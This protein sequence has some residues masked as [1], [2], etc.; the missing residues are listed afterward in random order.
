MIASIAT[1]V[2]PVWRSPMISSRWPRPIGTIESI[3]FRP[4]CTG[5]STD[6]RA[7]T[8]G[9]TFSMTS[10]ILA[11]IGPLPSIGWPSAL[12]TRPISS[13]PTG[14]S[15]MRLVHLTVSPSEICSKAP[16]MTAPT[17]SRS[18]FIAR[19]KVLPGNS[20]ISPC[21]TS[22]RPW[23][24]TIP[25]ATEI[26]VPWLR[27]SAPPSKPSIRLLISS[28]ISDG[29]S[30]ILTPKVWFSQLA[31]GEESVRVRAACL[32]DQSCAHVLQLG[33]H[34]RVEHFIADHHAHA[35][36]QRWIDRDDRVELAAEFLFQRRDQLGHLGRAQVEG[37]GDDGIGSA[38][39]A[40]FQRVELGADF[41]QQAEAAVFDQHRQEVLCFRIDRRFDQRHDGGDDVA[42]RH[43]RIARI[44]LHLGV[45]ADLGQF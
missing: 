27:T 39:H 13:G 32:S 7:I 16:R 10:V 2:L 22:D 18:R 17:E 4:V 40:V 33:L 6:L 35:A 29:L 5:W 42:L 25:S 24:R 23:M 37:T 36:D 45:A 1:A 44:R 43:F 21:I 11:L 15:R 28:L 30:C 8:P 31:R 12:T 41:R 20:S 26:T 14:T 19:P 34:R 3:D 9:A 38:F